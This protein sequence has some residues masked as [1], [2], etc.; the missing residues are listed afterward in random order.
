VPS[1]RAPA[2]RPLSAARA[3]APRS[4]RSLS[5]GAIVLAGS[6]TLVA[7]LL[8]PPSAQ[9][10]PSGIDEAPAEIPAAALLTV[11]QAVRAGTHARLILPQGPVHVWIPSGYHSDG[12]A[13]VV[14]VHGYYDSVDDAW[15]NHKLPEQFALAGCNALF[16]VP[17]AP[18]GIG[19]PVLFPD[20]L[21]LIQ[22]V[23]SRM[24]VW[25]GSGPL[26]AV[27]HSGAYRT[28]QRWLDEPL[29]DQIMLVDALY[30]EQESFG[31]WLAASPQRRLIT[32]GDD[33]VRWTEELAASIA[34]T[35]IADHF[36]IAP[37]GWTAEQRA[38]RHLYVRSQFGHMAQ[39]TGGVAL[40][41]LLRL[42]PVVRL[43]DTA[44]H[45]PLGQLPI[46]WSAPASGVDGGDIPE[47]PD[48]AP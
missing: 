21:G 5:V 27:G 48:E 47:V 30:G 18:E 33:T 38:A 13:T 35:E 6:A 43:P 1:P 42:L 31:G 12:A 25:R 37:E 15:V 16:I 7:N 26:V 17:E 2:I 22:E 14:Y 46:P 29:L 32:V 4:W 39:I 10:S 9:T 44:W 23:E 3:R 11:D 19:Q 20:L 28:L 36:P 34:E 24:K 45:Q 8:L 41:L 40:P